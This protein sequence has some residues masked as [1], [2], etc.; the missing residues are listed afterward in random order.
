MNS[1][2]KTSPDEAEESDD[3][4]SAEGAPRRSVL[5]PAFFA[6]AALIVV[7]A[8][9]VNRLWVTSSFETASIDSDDQKASYGIG[10]QV[11]NQLADAADNL[12]GRLSCVD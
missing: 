1:T 6:V 4:T 5:R 12:I 7:G 3:G 2:P 8:I 11:G 10:L 9:A